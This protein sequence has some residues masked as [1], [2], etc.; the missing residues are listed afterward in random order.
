MNWID[1]VPEGVAKAQIAWERRG[2][3]RR[4][5]EAGMPM[6]KIAAR[7]GVSRT[8]IYRQYHGIDTSDARLSTSP[9]ERYLNHNGDI[10]LLGLKISR[11]KRRSKKVG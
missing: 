5:H 2:S 4:A 9:V 3:I 8:R 11:A 6:A 7:L 10:A 1:L